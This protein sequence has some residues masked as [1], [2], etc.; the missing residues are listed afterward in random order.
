MPGQSFV[1]FSSVVV[2]ALVIVL[3]R[4]RR[5]SEAL[6]LF[7]LSFAALMMAGTSFGFPHYLKVAAWIGVVYPPSALFLLA[8]L[9]LL[10]YTLY[11]SIAISSLNEQNKTLA[12]ELAL[13][14][15]EMEE[16]RRA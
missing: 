16:S 7:W 8:L 12:Q 3:V 11:L 5:L 9:F 6:S 4:N 1:F 15:L 10:V 13:L 14:R 2:L